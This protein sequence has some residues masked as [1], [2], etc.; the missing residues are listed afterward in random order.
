[1]PSTQ[2]TIALRGMSFF[3]RHGYYEAEHSLGRKFTVDVLITSDISLSGHSDD[4][5]ET[6]NY[7]LVYR[8]VA[9]VMA[10]PVKLLEH[11]VVEITERLVARF[12]MIQSITVTLTKHDPPLG[13]LCAA[14]EVSYSWQV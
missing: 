13:G 8:V 11:V 12:A 6:V 7:E 1:M 10:I 5:T 4:L 14:A 9:E 2:G 3:A